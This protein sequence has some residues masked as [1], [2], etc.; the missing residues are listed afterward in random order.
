MEEID[1]ITIPLDVEIQRKQFM[2]TEKVNSGAT[3]GFNMLLNILHR[4]D[5][6]RDITY[7]METLFKKVNDVGYITNFNKCFREVVDE[8]KWKPASIYKPKAAMLRFLRYIGIPDIFLNRVMCT[9]VKPVRTMRDNFPIVWRD[10]PYASIVDKWVEI[11]R[12]NSNIHSTNTIKATLLFYSGV[13]VP[14]LKVNLIEGTYVISNLPELVKKI[15]Y[16]RHR[17]QIL[18]FIRKILGD[19]SSDLSVIEK[20]DL[21]PVM[22]DSTEDIHRISSEH[23]DK[24]YIEAAKNPFHELVFILFVTTGLRVGGFLNIKL[25]DVYNASDNTVKDVGKTLEKGNKFISFMIVGRLKELLLHYI[26]TIR[27]ASSD[28]L[29]C[30]RWASKMS[31]STV[32]KLFKELASAA[33]LTGREFHLHALRHTYAHLL[34]EAGNSPDI[35]SKLLNHSNSAIT[36]K[37]Y[38]KESAAEVVKRAN[39]P[40]LNKP[41]KP[42]VPKFLSAIQTDEVKASS[43]GLRMSQLKKLATQPMVLPA[44]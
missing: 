35:I 26:N 28:Y 5:S 24:L 27:P 34:L 42:A 19:T 41:E 31:N 7:H 13:I 40:W 29:F 32:H 11:L 3:C 36:E 2:Q 21:A 4:M 30:T 43:R 16:Q 22:Y 37:Y 6:T 12:S 38:L 20:T 33:G 18:L 39:I 23:L 44:M 9:I 1:S 8:A 10:E 17:Q 15:K 14:T 25:K